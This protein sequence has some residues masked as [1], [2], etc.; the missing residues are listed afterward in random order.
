M[1]EFLNESKKGPNEFD[2]KIIDYIEGHSWLSYE[3]KEDNTLS[4]S[5][6]DNGSVSAERYSPIDYK[7][8]KRICE[9]K[10]GKIRPARQKGERRTFPKH[11]NYY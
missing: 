7:E 6:R 8:A 4:F 9:Q 10:S 5:T 1:N 2:K 11:I 3:G